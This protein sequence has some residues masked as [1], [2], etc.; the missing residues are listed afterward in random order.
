[1]LLLASCNTFRGS[2]IQTLHN[3]SAAQLSPNCR[4][5]VTT[6]RRAG[7]RPKHSL[8]SP[9]RYHPCLFW[10][11]VLPG[12]SS[13]V[14]CKL[15]ASLKPRDSAYVTA[16]PRGSSTMAAS[17]GE[18]EIAVMV[19]SCAGKMGNATAHAVVRAGLTLVP[20]SLSGEG[21]RR[22][23]DGVDVELV[24][25]ENH[26]SVVQ[27]VKEQ[28]QNLIVV[29]Y[30]LPDVV[31]ANCEFYS[32][33]G[34]NFVVGTTG[35]DT[36]K[37]MQAAEDAG[38]YAVIAPNMGKQIVATQAMVEM[39]AQRFPGAFAGYKL[40]VVESHQKTKVDT[41]GTA[42]AVVESMAALG[43]QPFDMS[44]IEKLRDEKSS[45]EKLGVPMDAMNGHAFHT[46][47]LTSPEG[48]V[49]I[50]V[51]HNVIG[52]KVYAEGTVDACIFLA[53]RVAEGAGKKI[54]NMVDVLESG[55]MR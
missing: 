18:K 40:S 31:T 52:R 34:L 42:K 43:C 30:T 32:R 26:S 15:M 54:Y 6:S 48:D 44:E 21:G 29:D 19:N 38:V 33:Q 41:S 55:F 16:T 24:L 27:K 12:G 5:T 49:E 28:H 17:A 36:K 23:V 47:T 4:L 13:G 39:L 25:P 9:C 53:R 22:D 45:H 20:F 46:Y 8:A 11:K 37:M 7:F 14:P 3:M 1:M 51:Q 10:T 50:A 35:G 2:A